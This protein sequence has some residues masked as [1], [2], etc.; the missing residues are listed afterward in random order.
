MEGKKLYQLQSIHTMNRYNFIGSVLLLAI[1]LLAIRCT[2]P[3]SNLVIPPSLA[4][5]MGE[6]NQSYQVTSDPATPYT[7]QVGVTAVAQEARS[8]TVNIGSSTGAV[9]GTHYTLTG[10]GA[11]RSL[12][13]ASGEA[14]AEFQITGVFNQYVSG[15][16]DTLQ[17]WLSEPGIE[18]AQYLDTI[19]LVLRGPCFDGDV[20]EADLNAMVGVY[21]NCFDAG[22]DDW[23]PY[24]ARVV[25]I[26]PLTATTARAIINNVFDY[27]FGDVPFIMDWTDPN[28]TVINVEA[29]T[30]V[31]A[32]AGLLNGAYAG[33]NF[34]IRAAPAA[35]T[36]PNNFSVCN[37]RL[38]LRY[39]LGVYDPAT[40]TLLGFFGTVATTTMRR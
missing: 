28:N 12:T 24:T 11:G 35:S 20:T 29:P 30:I 15:R 23:G 17:I 33:M 36:V 2:K 37:S 7:I 34:V 32:D 27:G 8:V 13:I 39:Q 31:P 14:I 9:E 21:N 1:M 6:D 38:N 22:F 19:Q 5:F 10:L 26:T 4:K 40:S 16:K 3:S 25:S 18:V